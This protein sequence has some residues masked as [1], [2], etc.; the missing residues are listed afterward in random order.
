MGTKWPEH[1]LEA[2]AARLAKD[3]T[4][5]RGQELVGG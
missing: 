3:I 1:L 2:V 5:D 4:L